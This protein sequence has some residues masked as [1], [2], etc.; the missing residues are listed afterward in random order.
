MLDRLGGARVFS[1]I[2]LKSGYWQMPVREQDIPKT[3]FRTRWGLDEF[4]V[5][6]FGVT[7]APLQFMNMMN[8]VLSDYLDD[9]V[10]VFLDDTLVYSHT[11]EIYAEHLGKVLEALRRHCLFAMASKCNIMEEDVEFFG[12]WITPQG[13]APLKQKTKAVMEW[14]A[15]QDLKG[16]RSFLG[17]ANYYR[18]F[19]QGYAEL[20][21]PLSYLTKK[22]VPWVGGHPQR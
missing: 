18:C 14:E 3:A 2:D 5:M 6:P 12:Q 22:N 21:S 15:P 17:F 19:L 8:D 20:V 4:F 1:K 16:G 7:N 10:L 9:F 13:S 11:V